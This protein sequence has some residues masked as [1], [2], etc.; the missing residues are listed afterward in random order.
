MENA[1]QFCAGNIERG[2]IGL[3]LEQAGYRYP[4]YLKQNNE[5]NET[6]QTSFVFFLI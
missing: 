2:F 4:K 6:I 1:I 3:V 5:N